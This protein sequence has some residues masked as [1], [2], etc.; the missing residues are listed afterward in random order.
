MDFSKFI[1][2]AKKYYYRGMEAFKNEELD[3]F[4]ISVIIDAVQV[5]RQEDLEFNYYCGPT[6]EFS[7]EFYCTLYNFY[8]CL[9]SE[10]E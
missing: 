4:E 9:Y 8:C 6:D 7:E 3:G 10:E 1:Y 2:Y 5:A